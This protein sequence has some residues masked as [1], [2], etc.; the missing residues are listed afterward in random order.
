MVK[1]TFMEKYPICSVLLPK[2]ESKLKSLDEVLNFF[3]QKI[4][5]H[6]KA[7][8]IAIFD[9]YNHTKSIGG[10]I[11]TEIK[12]AKNILF[13][14]G[15]VIPNPKALALRTRSLGIC[16]LENAFDIEF[17]EAPNEKTQIILE[18]WIDELLQIK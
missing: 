18:S 11:A 3:E 9:H 15:P 1:S 5:T 4:Q 2:E 7:T 16:E 13:C 12:D 17:M 6:P 8:F 10:E 14:F